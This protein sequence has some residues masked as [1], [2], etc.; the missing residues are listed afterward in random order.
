M[1]PGSDL[2]IALLLERA[3]N[4]EVYH[5]PQAFIAFAAVIG[6]SFVR[7]TYPQMLKCK[8]GPGDLRDNFID[9]GR[10]RPVMNESCSLGAPVAVERKIRAPR[11]LFPDGMGRGYVDLVER[12][13]QEQSD[14]RQA[15]AVGVIPQHY[16]LDQALD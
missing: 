13:P 16:R 7:E 5:R 1:T 9:P 3:R 8:G 11:N 12:S 10:F 6:S 14:G 2:E 15:A 4:I